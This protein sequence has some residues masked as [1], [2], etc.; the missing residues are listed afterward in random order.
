MT[1]MRLA[2]LILPVVLLAPTPASGECAIP[3]AAAEAVQK[4]DQE[5]PVN[6]DGA[7]ESYKRAH[8]LAPTEHRILL[9][10]IRA[11]FKKESWADVERTAAK[12][13]EVAPK[14]A[15]YALYRGI[16]FARQSKWPEAKTA[17]EHAVALDVNLADAHYELA[18]V[19]LR[20]G[21]EKLALAEYTKAIPLAPEDPTFYAAL[22]DLYLRLGFSGNAERVLLAGETAVKNEA[23]TFALH[24]IHGQ[25]LEEKRDF[26]GAVTH[27]E[28]AKSACGPCVDRGQHIAFFNLGAAYASLTPPRK[29]EAMIN[30][31]KFQKMVCKGAAAARYADQCTQAQQIASKLGGMLQ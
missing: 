21:D 20:L 24:S 28:Q 5:S 15:P 3:G 9:K 26:A 22:A 1:S 19:A 25:I 31:Q 30:L 29:S 14:H 11:Y 4:G 12:A 8:A 18:E 2:W 16:G 17:L 13:L 6:L 23:K 7:I 27:Y 10:L